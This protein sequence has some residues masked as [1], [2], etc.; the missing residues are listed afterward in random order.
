[1]RTA[2]QA[3][4]N[5]QLKQARE[6]RGWSQKY[7]AEQIGAASQRQENVPPVFAAPV[8]DPGIPPLSSGAN[9]LVGR[10]EALSQLRVRLCSG[11][12]LVLTALNGLPGVGKT[13][14]AIAL[15]HD[16][17]VLAHFHDGIL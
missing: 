16:A 5:V 10:D 7:V 9:D 14:L 8:Y 2:A 3:I 17:Q 6:L 11:N 4:P 13:T 12:N 1:M 15:V